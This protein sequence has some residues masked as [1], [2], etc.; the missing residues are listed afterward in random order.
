VWETLDAAGY[1][2]RKEQLAVARDGRQFF[3]VMDLAT[4]VSGD[5]VSLSVGVRNSVDKTYAELA[6]ML[7]WRTD[8]G[9]VGLAAGQRST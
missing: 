4:P 5:R 6:V 7:T 8:L 9:L 1:H 2:V 3:G